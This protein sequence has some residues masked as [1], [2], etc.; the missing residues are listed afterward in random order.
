MRVH[1]RVE[2]LPGAGLRANEH[3]LQDLLGAVAA[4][5][6]AIGA[7]GGP[8]EVHLERLEPDCAVVSCLHL[9]SKGSGTA[10]AT[11]WT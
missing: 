2:L 1:A 11:E 6:V 3:A 10:G 4:E 7:F 9:G 5:E 8:F